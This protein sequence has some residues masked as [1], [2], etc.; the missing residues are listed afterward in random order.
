MVIS[1]TP[2]RMSFFGGGTDYKEYFEKYGG[3]VISA[4]FD[5]Y[6]FVTVKDFP[7]FFQFKNQL[8]YSRI[9]RFNE[10]EELTHPLVRE[11]Y[12]FLHEQRLQINY[13]SDLPA[14]SGIGSSSSFAVG[15]LNS[16]HTH[17]GKVC[18]PYTLATEAI[19]VERDMCREYGGIQD[20][21]AA[22]YGGFNR[23]DFDKSGF[24]VKPLNIRAD[25]L[26]LLNDRLMLFFSGLSRVAGEISREQA[27][28]LEKNVST[29]SDMKFLT[30]E[31]EKILLSGESLDSFG[32]LLDT[33]WRLKRR[34]AANIANDE[35]ESMYETAKRCG[36]VGGKLLGAG[37]G[38]FMLFYVPENKQAALREALQ[39]YMYVPFRFENEGSRI[40]YNRK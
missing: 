16:I 29:L 3:S 38:G 10:P 13:D 20:Q 7:P 25:R 34:L 9:E 37:G 1:R 21:I 32:E 35:V 12:H 2:F 5:K 27:D 24:Y 6:C 26:E 8:T 30:D 39:N 36:A 18:N 22:A 15:L 19:T 17:R 33:T 4:T 31:A 14:R 11:V 40:I 28:N 23:I